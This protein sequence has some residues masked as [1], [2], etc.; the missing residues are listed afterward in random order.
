M[1]IRDCYQAMGGDY[2]Q[3]VRR[4]SGEKM[5]ERFLARFLEGD[6]FP[7]L[8]GAME[9][10]KRK[11]AFYAADALKDVSGNL[12]FTGLLDSASALAEMLRAE[13]DA[14]PDGAEQLMDQLRKDYET[15]ADAIRG[16]LGGAE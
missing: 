11:E 14:I 6:C 15:T 16:Y 3:A 13:S 1:T 5:V 10:R 9:E 7:R 12:S 4:L 2:E 8:C